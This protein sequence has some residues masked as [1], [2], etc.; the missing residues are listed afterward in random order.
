[1]AGKVKYANLES[2]TARSRLKRGRNPHWQSLVPG[3]VHLG[4][5][6]WKGDKDGRWILRRNVGND[7]YRS[8]TLGRADDRDPA[9]GVHVLSYEQADAKARAMV[10]LPSAKVHNLTV[11]QAMARYIE[12]KQHE[13]KSTH[14]TAARAAVHILPHLG[15]L[16][17]SEL[18]AERL[19]RWLSSMASALAQSRPKNGKPQRRQSLTKICGGVETPPIVCW[20]FSGP[21]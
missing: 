10:D 2:K 16:V 7:K 9:D 3:R 4:Y 15:D 18:T 1:M 6:I 12:H 14:D 21:L 8:E 13:G 11:R 20:A 17:V 5:Q 19:Q